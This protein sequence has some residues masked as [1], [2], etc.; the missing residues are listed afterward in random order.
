MPSDT[1]AQALR[2]VSNTVDTTSSVA[3]PDVKVRDA[4]PKSLAAMRLLPN[5]FCAPPL[6]QPHMLT[7][8]RALYAAARM[9][10]A[11]A[12]AFRHRSRRADTLVCIAACARHPRTAIA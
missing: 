7:G 11:V 4:P 5:M 8:T 6:A 9:T 3:T 12:V 2:D 1:H 10:A